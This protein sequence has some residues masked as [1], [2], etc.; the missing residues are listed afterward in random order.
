M[1]V[2]SSF[3]IMLQE[4]P[5][6]LAK[7]SSETAGLHSKPDSW[8]PKQELG[9]LLDSAIMNHQRLLRVLREDN[10]TLP[11][12]DGDFCAAAHQYQAR[13][14][15]ELIETWRTLNSHFLWAIEGVSDAG[16]QRPCV[17]GGKPVTLEFLVSDYI[18]HAQH[19]LRH[20]GISAADLDQS[21]RVSA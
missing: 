21:S 12:Y 20:A 10:P 2:V 5:P 19:H 18:R 9:H 11:D 4:A 3:R 7:I 8:S 17:F 16:W 1:Q 14:W 6:R 13:T 15:Q